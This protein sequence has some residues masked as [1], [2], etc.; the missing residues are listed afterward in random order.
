MVITA[1]LANTAAFGYYETLAGLLLSRN[2]NSVIA[3]WS[4][5]IAYL[6]LF[7]IV[8]AGLQALLEKLGDNEVLFD[9]YVEKAGSPICGLVLGLIIAGVL[10]NAAGMSPVNGVPYKRFEGV[11]I[12]TNPQ[13]QVKK[14]FLN[15]DGF[16]AGLAG[17]LSKGCFSRGKSMAIF[18][19]DIVTEQFATKIGSGSNVSTLSSPDAVEIPDSNAVWELPEGITE[20]ENPDTSVSPESGKKLYVVRVGL[21][22]RGELVNPF[23]FSQLRVVCKKDSIDD[24]PLNGEG[25]NVYPHGYIKTRTSMKR[26]VSLDKQFNIEQSVSQGPVKWIDLVYE[27]PNNHT[28]VLFAFKRNVASQLPE[29]VEFR[30]VGQLKTFAGTGKKSSPDEPAEQQD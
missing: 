30:K 24:N 28:P 25:I 7:I 17:F 21:R 19:P 27:V 14:P 5:L 18:H 8:F 13:E 1:I 3:P 6:L 12:P 26:V 20:A 23:T 9:V 22:K 11:S 10:V 4:Y 2:I 29:P 15:P 16:T